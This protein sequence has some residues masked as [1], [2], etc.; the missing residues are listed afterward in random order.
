M[1]DGMLSWTALPEASEAPAGVTS[2]LKGKQHQA[3]GHT[4]VMPASEAEAGDGAFRASLGYIGI[5]CLNKNTTY[6]QQD[7]TP[8]ASLRVA[9]PSCQAESQMWGGDPRD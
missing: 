3:W 7:T 6:K 2:T 5:P 8:A 9:S 1:L 4:S